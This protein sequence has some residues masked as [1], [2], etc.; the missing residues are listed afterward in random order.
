MQEITRSRCRWVLG[1][2]RIEVNDRGH[3]IGESHPQCK[4]PDWAVDLILEL[5][6]EGVSVARIAAKFDDPAGDGFTVSK[7]YVWKV[8]KGLVRAQI[9]A[10]VKTTT[11]E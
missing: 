10:R 1:V 2:K 4:V 9:A 7:T 3:R 5:R 8:C 11:E 6:A